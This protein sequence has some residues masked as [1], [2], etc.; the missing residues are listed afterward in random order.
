MIRRRRPNLPSRLPALL[1]HPLPNF[2]LNLFAGEES[3]EFWKKQL[4]LLLAMSVYPTLDVA[5]SVGGVMK[6]LTSL[7]RIANSSLLFSFIFS[8]IFLIFD[9][10]HD[11]DDLAT[12]LS[13]SDLYEIAMRVKDGNKVLSVVFLKNLLDGMKEIPIDILRTSFSLSRCLFC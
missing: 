7:K 1:L 13:P 11:A 4:S 8:L 9:S 10:S 5:A 6:I 3:L 12:P 2:A